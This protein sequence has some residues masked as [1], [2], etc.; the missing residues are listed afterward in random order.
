M[1]NLSHSLSNKYPVIDS[2]Q[3][4]YGL[5]DLLCDFEWY[6]CLESLQTSQPELFPLEKQYLG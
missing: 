5:I 4:S 1:L 2:L 3:R 6:A